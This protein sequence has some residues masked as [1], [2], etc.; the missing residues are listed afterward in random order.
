MKRF[1]WVAGLALATPLTL[2][3]QF[4][5]FN[6][7]ALFSRY[8]S[9]PGGAVPVVAGDTL[10]R[11]TFRALTGVNQYQT[12]V[13]ILAYVSGNVTP[14]SLPSSLL[15]RTGL[16]TATDRMIL[17]GDGRLGIGTTTPATSLHLPADG[18]QIG[19]SPT[20]TN[21]FY[22][23]SNT[24]D[25]T[26]G[27]RWYN[28]N[29]GNGKHLLT[30]AENG[31]LGIAEVNPQERLVVNGNAHTVGN[32][33]ID[34]QLFVGTNYLPNADVKNYR[35]FSD[36]GILCTEVRILYKSNWPDYVFSK[37][38]PLMPLQIL[39][40]YIDRNRHLPGIPTATEV[41]AGGVEV[42]EIQKKLLEKMEEMTLYILQQQKEIDAL[43]NEIIQLKSSEK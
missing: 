36:G 24:N 16:N 25:G 15:F 21:N 18:Y 20:A 37:D 35:I 23:A 19:F 11:L 9:A 28:G 8:N 30:L 42:G 22:V 38:Y 29:A 7:N 6:P 17:T 34:K 5:G 2:V 41:A 3:A 14:N 33:Q 12:G 10:G 32:A 39:E 13:S 4:S 40:A 26:R 1:L 43:K 27:L 31:N